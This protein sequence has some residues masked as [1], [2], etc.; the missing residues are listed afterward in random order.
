MTGQQP[1]DQSFGPIVTIDW[2]MDH[3]DDP[4]LRLIDVRQFGENGLGHIPGAVAID[5]HALHLE[6]SESAAIQRFQ[7]RARA[8]LSAA[9]VGN[10]D[11][12]VFYEE[13]SGASA[14]RG[15]WVVDLLGL[16]SSAVLDGG[17]MAWQRAG[18]DI[19]RE[20]TERPPSDL[21]LPR[22]RR[23]GDSR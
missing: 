19:S 6:S 16:E 8:A 21:D 10:G 11:R 17:L 1:T 2:L 20:V 13:I 5:L 14:A 4:T 3:L 22:A 9:G 12:V 18:G 15:A 7:Q 23:T